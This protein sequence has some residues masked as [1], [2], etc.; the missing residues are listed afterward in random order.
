MF[1]MKTLDLIALLVHP[2]HYHDLQ[3]HDGKYYV[4]K[5]RNFKKSFTTV[6]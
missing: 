2:A 4:N 3:S 6:H 1:S 5:I